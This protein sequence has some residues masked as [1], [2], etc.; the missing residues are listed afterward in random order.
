MHACIRT[1]V[2]TY[3]QAS[4]HTCIHTDIH[5][6]L[7]TYI[8]TLHSIPFHCILLHYITLH[9]IT[10]HYNTYIRYIHTYTYVHTYIH[11]LY[12]ND[13]H[14][15]MCVYIYTFGKPGVDR[16]WKITQKVSPWKSHDSPA[17]AR[18]IV[19]WDHV[20]LLGFFRNHGGFGGFKPRFYGNVGIIMV[21]W[22]TIGISW[23]FLMGYTTI[24]FDI[25]DNQRWLVNSQLNGNS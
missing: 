22:D 5:T 7:R 24:M 1:Y 20:W 21:L 9:Y 15:N 8:H 17:G 4:M 23:I 14:S 10:L 19:S 2:H 16:L 25:W 6:Y 12:I 11:T 13:D 18:P 3:V